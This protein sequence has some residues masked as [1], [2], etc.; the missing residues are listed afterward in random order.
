MRRGAGLPAP[1][2]ALG[3]L[4]SL[5]ESDLQRTD[6]HDLAILLCLAGLCAGLAGQ[7]PS[8]SDLK[9]VA[10][11]YADTS[12]LYTGRV[13]PRAKATVELVHE[14]LEGKSLDKL[15]EAADSISQGWPEYSASIF[16]EAF[17]RLSGRMSVESAAEDFR[18][19]SFITWRRGLAECAAGAADRA[20]TSFGVSLAKY[21]QFSYYA[22]AAWLYTDLV[23]THLL[24][25]DQ[26]AAIRVLDEQRG[27]VDEVVAAAGHRPTTATTSYA[28]H[29][30][31]V[32]SGSYSS[33]VDSAAVGPQGLN[34]DDRALLRRYVKVS[35]SLLAY[36]RSHARRDLDAAVDLFSF[37][38]LGYLSS[39]YPE[40]F[41]RLAEHAEGSAAASPLL[42]AHVRWRGMLQATQLRLRS[43]EL[44]RT[45]TELRDRLRAAGLDREADIALLDAGMLHFALY[46]K[47]A[48]AAW[49][50]PQVHE[51]RRRVPGPLQ[52]VVETLQVPPQAG[53]Q[54]TLANYLGV[55]AVYRVPDFMS[56]LGV[57]RRGLRGRR[58]MPAEVDIAC[59]G[60]TLWINGVMI[61]ATTPPALAAIFR[62]LGQ[63]LRSARAE[64]REV[65][66]L[67]SVE[68]AARTGRTTTAIAQMV[69]RFR[70]V[71]QEQ[72]DRSTE[73]GLKPDDLLQGRPGYRFNPML[74]GEVA[75]H[76]ASGDRA[77]GAAEG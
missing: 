63:E 35:E 1:A 5:A 39:P 3:A 71:C 4:G 44:I 55:R 70:M 57:F 12:I 19:T 18:E 31:D 50:S 68:L 22:D 27:Y 52:A 2:D 54:S 41:R 75:F 36:S 11:R 40:I 13:L 28:F 64:D 9:A 73:L 56:A 29:L 33:F 74:V 69:R 66:F 24:T 51:L 25:D 14:G 37:G 59:C 17:F 10:D 38:W 53:L 48:T 67:S 20:L 49:L 21:R 23:L 15:V 30:G 58:E 46:G 42:T 61:Y 60:E 34:E 16:P 6:E 47:A 7:G 72:L 77:P 76:P 45:A 65:A 8:V 62:E 26:E 32:R 43:T